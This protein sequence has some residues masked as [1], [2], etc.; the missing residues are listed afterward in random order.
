VV[1][2]DQLLLIGGDD[3]A[4]ANAARRTVAAMRAPRPQEPSSRAE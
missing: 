4:L 3:L 1:P 2:G